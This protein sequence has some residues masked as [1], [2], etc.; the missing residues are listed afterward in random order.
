MSITHK[1]NPFRD[2]KFDKR[3]NSRYTFDNR[4]QEEIARLKI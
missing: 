3:I 1:C 4:R 2:I